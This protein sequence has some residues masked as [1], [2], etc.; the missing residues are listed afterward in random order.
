MGNLVLA[1]LDWVCACLDCREAIRLPEED[2]LSYN[3]AFAFERMDGGFVRRHEG[4]RL[5]YLAMEGL[6][7][8]KGP[9]HITKE[10]FRKIFSSSIGHNKVVL[11]SS[12][13]GLASSRKYSIISGRIRYEVKELRMREKEISQQIQADFKKLGSVEWVPDIEL[14]LR[15]VRDVFNLEKGFITSRLEH[16]IEEMLVREE[17][18][19]VSGDTFLVQPDEWFLNP[20]LHFCEQII[21]PSQAEFFKK[22]V[23]ENSEDPFGTLLT[24]AKFDFSVE[25]I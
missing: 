8:F 4:H 12:R 21:P 9:D 2:G 14:F 16:T 7:W 17:V 22:F 20:L 24:E 10:I 18:F 19:P 6:A 3:V 13:D 25:S 15:G 23:K 1:C 5:E 11:K